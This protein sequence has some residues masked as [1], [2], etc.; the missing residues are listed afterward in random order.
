LFFRHR[1]TAFRLAYRML[2]HEQDAQDA[3]QDALLKAVLGLRDFGGRSG[4]R[5]WLLKIVHNAALDVG[6]RRRRRPTQ[7]LADGETGGPKASYAHDPARGL[8]QQDLRR[9][10]NEALGRLSPKIRDT[11]VLFAEIGL[12]YKEIAEFQDIPMGTVMSR[13]SHA[14]QKLQSYLDLEGIEGI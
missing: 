10:L 8:H 14:R 6:R 12:S 9:I 7:A 11:F 1:D 5:T 2:G 4:F 13:L 3:V